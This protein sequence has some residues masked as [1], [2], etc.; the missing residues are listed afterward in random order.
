MLEMTPDGLL[1]LLDRER[2]IP[3]EG[4]PVTICRSRYRGKLTSELE[5]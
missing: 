4:Y 1:C 3:Y 2:T 5:S